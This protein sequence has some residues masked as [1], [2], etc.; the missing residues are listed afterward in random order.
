[1]RS[2]VHEIRNHLAVAIANVEAFREGIL[3]PTSA[4]LG[5]VLQALA[6]IEV[7]LA[8]IPR[9]IPALERR[10][11]NA[12]IDVS[13][14]ISIE[15]AALEDV[16]KERGI[17]FTYPPAARDDAG[18]PFEGDPVRI[19]ELVGHVVASAIRYTPRGGRVAVDQRR[20]ES[21][22]H[23]TVACQGSD[24]AETDRL[25]RIFAEAFSSDAAAKD[26]E[27]V[28]IAV[29]RRFVEQRGGTL[30]AASQGDLRNPVIRLEPLSFAS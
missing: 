21:S 8:E 29:M 4:R 22:V 13:D 26:D 15:L 19:A 11:H 16:A 2:V 1:M 20:A 27:S 6:E 7:L 17:G 23:I 5:A 28:G 30:G 25:A 3:A 18:G 12:P 9:T 14:I 10:A 24:Q